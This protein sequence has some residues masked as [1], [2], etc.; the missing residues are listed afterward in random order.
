MEKIKSELIKLKSIVL[1]NPNFGTAV[2]WVAAFA[3]G[4][5]SVGY[6]L[7]FRWGD[8]LF[9]H[10]IG[11]NPYMLWILPPICFL[12]S[13]MLVRWIAPEAGGSGIP[14]GLGSQ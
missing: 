6:S 11:I 7:A 3:T 13:G 9:R 4:L 10:L 1:K 5:V 12:A 2:L 14:P 8:M